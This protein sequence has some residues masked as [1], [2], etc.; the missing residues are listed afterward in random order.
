MRIVRPTI[1]SVI[2][3]GGFLCSVALQGC[4]SPH[5]ATGERILPMHERATYQ[6]SVLVW[7]DAQHATVTKTEAPLEIEVG[8][9]FLSTYL[10]ALGG[11]NLALNRDGLIDRAGQEGR[12]VGQELY[13]YLPP[14]NQVLIV[15]KDHS[16]E[17]PLPEAAIRHA[18][19]GKQLTIDDQVVSTPIGVWPSPVGNVM[20][21]EAVG[22]A[23]MYGVDNDGTIG[24]RDLTI[25]H[26]GIADLLQQPGAGWRLL[27]AFR[28][29]DVTD[30]KITQRSF[31]DLRDTSLE[32]LRS[33]PRTASVFC[34]SDSDAVTSAALDALHG[35][36]RGYDEFD[37]CRTKK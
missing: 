27:R 30:P 26:R 37:V 11:G 17:S 21:V 8:A 5:V 3:V 1:A 19:D 22:I 6:A 13:D 35:D 29:R 36:I 31:D 4:A 20:R 10:G 32:E 16:Y 28:V 12:A 33:F 25:A 24:W 15:D 18:F 9:N 34:L 23:R 2:T 7:K 14:A